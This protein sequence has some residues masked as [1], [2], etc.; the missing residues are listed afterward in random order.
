MAAAEEKLGKGCSSTEAYEDDGEMQGG[1][2]AADYLAG[3]GKDVW[4][5][6]VEGGRPSCKGKSRGE[7]ILEK[8][9]QQLKMELLEGRVKDKKKSRSKIPESSE[10]DSESD[11]D[12]DSS[13]SPVRRHRHR[14]TSSEEST[15]RRLRWSASRDRS[16]KCK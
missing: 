9:I 15:G 1:A 3:P 12:S 8:R 6:K 7:K 11:S 2:C 5:P 16:K 4:G 13:A 10:D 14:S